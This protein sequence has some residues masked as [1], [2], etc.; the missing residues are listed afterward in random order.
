MP[1]TDGEEGSAGVQSTEQQLKAQADGVNVEVILP[2]YLAKGKL[3]LLI[4]I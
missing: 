4:K 2:R 3:Y 1:P